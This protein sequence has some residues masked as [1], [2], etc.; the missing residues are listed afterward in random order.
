MVIFVLY[1]N[2]NFRNVSYEV[3]QTVDI[4]MPNKERILDELLIHALDLPPLPVLFLADPK[5]FLP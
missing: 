1:W 2:H 5:E 3:A 4:N